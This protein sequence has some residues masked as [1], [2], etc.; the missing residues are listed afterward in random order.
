MWHA[1]NIIK[2]TPN[3]RGDQTQLL[4]IYIYIVFKNATPSKI[5]AENIFLHFLAIFAI[6][7]LQK[8]LFLVFLF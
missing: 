1:Q 2:I 5:D 6:F 4:H 7:K 3:E 8:A